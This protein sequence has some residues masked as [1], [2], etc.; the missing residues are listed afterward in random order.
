MNTKKLIALAGLSGTGKTTTLMTL[1]KRTHFEHL[2]ASEL[3]KEQRLIEANESASSEQL[4]KGDIQDNQKLFRVAF[5]RRANQVNIPV[6][7][8]CHTLIDT[9]DGLKVMP[10]EIF[11]GLGLSHFTFLSVEPDQLAHRR[12]Y[13]EARE[14]PERSEEELLQHHN[15]AL[16]QAKKVAG[17]LGIPFVEICEADRIRSLTSLLSGP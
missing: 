12:R 13:D 5:R 11:E 6:I 1:I 15:I 2:S 10:V 8:D 9:P 7:L 14:R 3:I 4:R 17:Y 16:N